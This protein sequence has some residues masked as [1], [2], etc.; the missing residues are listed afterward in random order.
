MTTASVS[1]MMMIT[2]TTPR[3]VTIGSGFDHR[4]LRWFDIHPA[5]DPRFLRRFFIGW[6]LRHRVMP[7]G[8]IDLPLSVALKLPLHFADLMVSTRR[9]RVPAMILAMPIDVDRTKMLP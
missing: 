9:R 1:R 4:E 7:L 2:I 8:L 5:I 3:G 6:H